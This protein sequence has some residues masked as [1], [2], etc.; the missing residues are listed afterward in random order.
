MGRLFCEQTEAADSETREATTV[1]TSRDNEKLKL[2]RKLR[3]RKWRERERLFVTEG[4]DLLAAGLAAGHSPAEVLVAAEA[5]VAGI[6]VEP[7]LLA[8]ASALGS[9]TRVIA[10]WQLP[11]VEPPS[12]PAVYLHGVG[13][14]GNVGTIVRTAAALTGARV[15]LGPGCA[16]AYSPKAV[17]AS[18][19]AMFAAPPSRAPIEATAP[20]RLALVAH[21]GTAIDD[22]LVGLG[23]E[24]TL[25]FGAERE[26]LPSAVADAC[27]ASATIPL[28]GG[29]ESL[30]V[31]A[32]A[33]I[34]LQRISSL[35][36]AVG[37]D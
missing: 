34:A 2:V 12:G 37:C 3:E 31:A 21:G 35:A 14:P 25:C 15:V 9:G 13:D 19:G 20:P 33:A 6:E 10:A 30:N 28:R 24:P 36:A 29:A 22:A 27:D 1:I 32:A 17:R 16:D 23:A 4:E 8:A 7:D 5:G 11:D 18:M 26:G